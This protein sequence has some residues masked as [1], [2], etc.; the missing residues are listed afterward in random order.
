MNEP[1][2][3]TEEARDL[4]YKLIDRDNLLILCRDFLENHLKED[5]A[6]ELFNKIS[7][8]LGW[9]PIFKRRISK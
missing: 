6:K 3:M 8:R 4:W 7:D 5:G 9:S 2:F 1:N